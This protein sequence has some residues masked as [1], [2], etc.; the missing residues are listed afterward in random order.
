MSTRTRYFMVG[1]ALVLVLGLCTGLV[2]YYNG[3]L[4]LLT[5]SG[6]PAELAYLPAGTAGVA[7]AN[8][9][10]IMTS[11]FRQK[12]RQV[13]PTGEEKDKFQK[14]TSIDI[15][16]DIDTVLAGFKGADP[17]DH[18]AVILVRGRFNQ[19]QIEA[20][21]REHGGSVTE[22]RGKRLMLTHELP[23]MGSTSA[24]APKDA[25][26]HTTGGLA[27]LESGLVALGEQASLEQAIDARATGQNVTKN[28][29]LM[30]FVTGIDATNNAWVVGQMD[31]VVN[32]SAVPQQAK[33]Q[34]ATVQ[35]F[36]ITARI[37][38]GVSGMV[39]AEARDDQ[40]GEDLRSVVR[41]GLAAAHLMTSKDPKMDNLLN[42][43]Q[44]S[45]TGKTVALSFTVSPDM[46][47]MING[48]AG[49]KH[50]MNGRGK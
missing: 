2:A 28:A 12:L 17:S 35:W 8:V 31:A 14:E 39:R 19:G 42:S 10:A 45:G 25:P 29:E 44:L 30:K 15:E 46:L 22:Y 4:P 37:D 20:L 43:L 16:K 18:A 50:L 38:A 24:D 36:E 48:M 34:L 21:V 1:S 47:D 41:G 9:H 11:A 27:F 32:S 40:A 49:L 3:D 26:T 13:L 7:Y 33:D 5:S 6:G 23:G